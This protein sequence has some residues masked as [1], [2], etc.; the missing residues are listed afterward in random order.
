MIQNRQS[1]V[2]PDEAMMAGEPDDAELLQAVV[3]RDPAALMALY[4]RYGRLA[5]GLA[6]RIL[7]DAG[8]AEEAVQ[9]AFLL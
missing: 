1:G 8:A 2:G 7:G 4:D 5:F 9:D 3:R 6:Y